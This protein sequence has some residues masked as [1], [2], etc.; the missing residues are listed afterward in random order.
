MGDNNLLMII[1]AFVVG[2]MLQ[3]MM[4]NMCGSR[5]LEGSVDSSI[6]TGT[7]MYDAENCT[8]P[9]TF[10]YCDKRV[11]YGSNGIINGGGGCMNGDN[12]QN[13]RP[14]VGGKIGQQLCTKDNQCMYNQ[15]YK[16]IPAYVWNTC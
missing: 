8:C 3:G 13:G 1:L 11:T 7:S 5:L 2:Y 14:G 15:K 9:T 4:K 12:Y 6:C 10:P 16:Y